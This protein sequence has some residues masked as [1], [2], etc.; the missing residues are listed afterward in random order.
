MRC[1]LGFLC[2]AACLLIASVPGQALAADVDEH[3][4]QSRYFGDDAAAA[5]A[6]TRVPAGKRSVAGV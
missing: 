5:L 1:R 3:T 4:Y 2:L 6:D